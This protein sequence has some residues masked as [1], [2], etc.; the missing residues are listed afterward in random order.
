MS[1]TVTLRAKLKLPQLPNFLFVEGVTASSVD[2]ALAH[3]DAFKVDVGSLDDQAISDFCNAWVLAF[4]R[5]A[6][7]RRMNLLP[8]G[9]Q[10]SS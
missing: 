8:K 4:T 7:E 6:K 9:P 2:H 3:G 1:G 5:H 10:G